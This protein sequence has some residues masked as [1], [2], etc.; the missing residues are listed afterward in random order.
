MAY[1]NIKT[2]F[3]GISALRGAAALRSRPCRTAGISPRACKDFDF[4]Y[5]RSKASLAKGDEILVSTPDGN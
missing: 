1:L 2:F 4:D 5:S 3:V